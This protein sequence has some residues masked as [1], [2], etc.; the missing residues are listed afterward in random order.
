MV[1]ELL[2]VSLLE[3]VDKFFGKYQS[4]FPKKVRYGFLMC[5]GRENIPQFNHFY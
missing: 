2:L 3:A 5:L 4:I 1:S